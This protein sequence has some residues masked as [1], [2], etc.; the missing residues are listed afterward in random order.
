MIPPILIDQNLL[1]PYDITCEIHIDFAKIALLLM[2][3]I[4]LLSDPMRKRPS[5]KIKRV[6]PQILLLPKN[7]NF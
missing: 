5:P 1:L 7:L 4:V 3:I 6:T 2:C